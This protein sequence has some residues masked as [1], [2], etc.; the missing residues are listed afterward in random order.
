MNTQVIFLSPVCCRASCPKWLVPRLQTPPV[1]PVYANT[2][3]S[4][5]PQGGGHADVAWIRRSLPYLEHE[6]PTT[7]P[8]R[9]PSPPASRILRLRHRAEAKVQN[10]QR[11]RRHQHRPR[12]PALDT[13]VPTP[14][15]PP[16]RPRRSRQVH[17]PFPPAEC[18]LLAAGGGAP[19]TT[20]WTTS[21]STG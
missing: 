3:L 7:M 5:D 15:R 20:A 6:A 18:L 9:P 19:R 1:T 10:L 11:R 13:R 16:P 14:P 4:S 12:P 17:P 2:S 21:P 8:P